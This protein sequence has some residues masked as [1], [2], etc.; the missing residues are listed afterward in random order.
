[1][2]KRKIKENIKIVT[3]RLGEIFP[4]VKIQLDFRTPFELLVAT[5]LSAQCTDARVNQVTAIMFEKYYKPEH[6]AGL[7]LESIEALIF[8]TGYYKAK[9]RHIQEASRTIIEEFNNE[10]PGTMDELLTIPG[11]GRKTANVILGHIF[12]LPAVVVD[13]HVIRIINRLGFADTTNPEKIEHI[14]MELLPEDKWVIFT[15]YMINFGRKICVAR[16]PRCK[17]CMLSDIC[18]S[19]GIDLLK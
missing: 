4:F 11:V 15:H 14:L 7:S 12:N 6:F 17:E 16:K 9:A 8:S 10:V 1:M 3:G 2:T 19:A 18:P 13:T 5:I